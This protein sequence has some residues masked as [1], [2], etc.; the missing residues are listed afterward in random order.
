[1]YSLI[2]P[3]Q[4]VEKNSRYIKNYGIWM[5]YNSRSGTSNMYREYRDVSLTGA[6][7][8]MYQDMAG[9]HR[10]RA[11]AIQ[12]IGTATVK[13]SE[14]RREGVTQFHVN[15]PEGRSNLKFPLPHRIMRAANKGVK[16]TYLASRPQTH[17]Q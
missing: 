13:D 3:L 17:F 12:V 11:G 7:D 5:K 2:A 14:C 10:T 1:L 16:A 6:I 8:T 4:I 9:R 15:L